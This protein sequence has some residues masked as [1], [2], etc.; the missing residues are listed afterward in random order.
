MCRKRGRKAGPRKVRKR[1][2]KKAGSG[3]GKHLTETV[4]KRL[5]HNRDGRVLTP[6]KEPGR[7]SNYPAVVFSSR[8]FKQ[9]SDLSPDLRKKQRK[10]KHHSRH[11]KSPKD[12]PPGNGAGQQREESIVGGRGKSMGGAGIAQ[13]RGEGE[14]EGSERSGGGVQPEIRTAG[15]AE[16][17]AIENTGV[18]LLRLPPTRRAGTQPGPATGRKYK[19]STTG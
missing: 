14:N 9:L 6:E 5:Y 10:H 19:T 7:R 12:D 4:E 15:R 8:A 13:L 11:L 17:A 2:R 1:G 18:P 16:L 3:P